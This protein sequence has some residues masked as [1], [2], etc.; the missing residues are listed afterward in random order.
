M[1]ELRIDDISL[2][3]TVKGE[4]EP[5]LLIHGNGSNHQE[6]AFFMEAL[7]KQFQVYA[8]DSRG[9]G[10]SSVGNKKYTIGL[11]SEDILSACEQLGI[12]KCY[13]VGYSDGGNIILKMN[14][15]NP[16]ILLKSVLISPN[17]N[18]LGME[19]RWVVMTNILY[20]WF[21]FLGLFRA[22]YKHKSNIIRLMVRGCNIPQK[23]LQQITSE[24]LIL[25]AEHDMIR[26]I[27]LQKLQTFIP[28]STLICINDTTHF[29]IIEN[30]NARDHIIQ[31]LLK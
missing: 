31:F 14:E 16:N 22:K 23:A 7:Q 1:N 4:K 26:K 28:K 8:F 25:Y 20:L 13:A 27:H 17:Y 2:R 24:T 19:F 30:E 12:K 11:L 15:K 21:T 9:H 5:L 6:F 29:T 3:Y 18:V 10:E